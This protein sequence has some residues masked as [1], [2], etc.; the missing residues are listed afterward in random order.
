MPRR[1]SRPLDFHPPVTEHPGYV[2]DFTQD[3]NEAR[4]RYIHQFSSNRVDDR[5]K[6]NHSG[7]TQYSYVGGKY[8][9]PIDGDKFQRKPNHNATAL[10]S[11]MKYNFKNTQ[12]SQ[13]LSHTPGMRQNKIIHEWRKGD[14]LL[15]KTKQNRRPPPGRSPL[16][17]N[18]EINIFTGHVKS[19]HAEMK[20]K[21]VRTLRHKGINAISPIAGINPRTNGLLDGGEK[22]SDSYVKPG[23]PPAS[24]PAPW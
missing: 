7:P 23:A 22:F 24:K 5:I 1:N 17:R 2:G 9:N 15:R 12:Y 14:Q 4:T 16:A 10:S 19:K 6:R 13:P 20:L 18:A 11:Q 8:P 21:E 3:Q